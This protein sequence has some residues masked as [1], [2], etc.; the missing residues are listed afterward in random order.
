MGN[1]LGWGGVADAAVGFHKRVQNRVQNSPNAILNRPGLSAEREKAYNNQMT[2]IDE[3]VA[4]EKAGLQDPNSAFSKGYADRE[5]NLKNQFAGM[6]TQMSEQ[7]QALKAE[8]DRGADRAAAAS[9][10]PGGGAQMK[11]KQNA[12]TE[13]GKTYAAAEGGLTA[14][15]AQTMEGLQ[16]VKAQEKL[17]REQS[18]DANAQFAKTLGFQ[19][20]SFNEQMNYSWAELNE[21]QRNDI[22]NAVALLKS[23]GL[24]DAD[25][26]AKYFGQ[27]GV[28][29][30]I[31]PGSPRM[32]NDWKD[33]YQSSRKNPTNSG[34]A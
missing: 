3:K 11:M 4:S 14:Q 16:S 12:A 28:V 34:W 25:T 13:L 23:E 30:Q 21:T 26:L 6:R 18:I 31:Y 7:E 24:G 10:G 19:N 5:A 15:E 33:M 20:K 29:P 22:V 2:A 17:M 8:F 27:G 32:T 1:G 9:G